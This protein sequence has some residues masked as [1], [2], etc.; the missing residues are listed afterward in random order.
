MR[1]HGLTLLASMTGLTMMVGLLPLLA[2][3]TI[4]RV[5]G[6]SPSTSAHFGVLRLV[7]D[8]PDAMVSIDATGFGLVPGQAGATL[9]YARSRMVFTNDLSRCRL[10]I[11][12]TGN[13]PQSRAFWAEALRG[14]QQACQQ[15]EK[16][17]GG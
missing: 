13:D 11:F 12:E 16:G 1:S 8:S 10:V 2:G 5:E 6:A 17:D 4:V 3:C 7:P 15:G 14:V 9:G